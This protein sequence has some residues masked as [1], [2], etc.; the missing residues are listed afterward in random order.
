MA[1]E[2]FLSNQIITLKSAMKADDKPSDLTRYIGGHNRRN[3][4]Y[5]NGYHQIVVSPP[6][7]LFS[8]Q[9]AE[10]AS[11]LS[12][13]CE[14]FTPHSITTN[15]A[16]IVGLGQIGSSFPTSRT[17]N[18]EFTLTFREYRALPILNIIRTWHALFN[19]HLGISTLTAAEFIPVNYKGWIMVGI[20][21]PT[22]GNESK[23][24]TDD[25]EEVYM[26]EGVF[27]SVCPDDT[28]TTIDQ[29]TQDSVQASIT[30]KF[31]G[32]PLDKSY[33]GLVD[34]YVT[35][36]GERSYAS[37]YKNIGVGIS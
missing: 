28:I 27:P 24:T 17:V 1:S 19:T 37:T 32:A 21:K 4:P 34:K 10:A 7:T 15:F 9:A 2:S 25:I 14:G 13:T 30:F 22:M 29:A 33:S 6:S 18:R 16:D 26:Y 23:I 31:D 36:L 20:L 8:G 11:W 5:I 35:M 12:S 3:Q